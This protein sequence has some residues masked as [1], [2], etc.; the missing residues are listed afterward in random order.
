[1]VPTVCGEVP[2]SELG[3]VLPHEHV[4]YDIFQHSGRL[5]N[6]QQVCVQLFYIWN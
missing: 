3:L 2:A 5:D 4:I 1:M 6:L